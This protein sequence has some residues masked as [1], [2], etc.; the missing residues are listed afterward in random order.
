MCANM[1]VGQDPLIFLY[2]LKRIVLH[3]TVNIELNI[4]RLS[5]E[6]S[7]DQAA[8]YN[9]IV[10]DDLPRRTTIIGRLFLK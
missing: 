6:K 7:Q 8:S 9:K 4:E 5:Y 1:H 10:L 2:I 3:T